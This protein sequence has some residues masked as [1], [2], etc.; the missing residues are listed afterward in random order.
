M[1]EKDLKIGLALGGGGA[2]GFAHIGVLKALASEF[3]IHCVAGTSMGALVGGCFAHRPDVHLLEQ[4]LVGV[5]ERPGLKSIEN[6]ISGE[7][8]AEGKELILQALMSFVKKFYLL[9]L[10]MMRRWLFSGRE[11]AD[12]FDELGLNVDFRALALPFACTAV[13][14]RSGEEFLL[15]KGNVKNSILA[16]V[17]LPGVFPPCKR[18]ERLLVDG[19]VV[20]SV[21]VRA[22]RALGADIVIAV[23]VD[24]YIPYI[25]KLGTGLDI[26]F[27]TDA[28]RARALNAL[29]LEEADFVISPDVAS[30]SW[31][32][33]SRARECVRAGERAAEKLKPEIMKFLQVKQRARRWQKIFPFFRA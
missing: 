2:R 1:G 5:C 13:D 30:I 24:P 20:G 31:A 18:G 25:R 9:N 7:T 23:A 15:T 19:G 16:S 4:H 12:I 14:L 28:I 10:R 22:A 29:I 8:F 27:Q 21:P 33:F 17:A 32:A 3:P 26:L 6:L 11:I